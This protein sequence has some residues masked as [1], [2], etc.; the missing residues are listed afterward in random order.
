M[1]RILRGVLRFSS[2]GF[3]YLRIASRLWARALR[4]TSAQTGR[5]ASLWASFRALLRG[6]FCVLGMCL[7]KTL[8][9]R[10]RT[11]AGRRPLWYP[12]AKDNTT[13]EVASC[14]PERDWRK[15]N[16]LRGNS[17]ANRQCFQYLAHVA[18]ANMDRV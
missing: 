6:L 5:L 11:R 1:D 18:V 3:T 16:T 2:G 14:V 17:R 7:P 8:I 12:H 4:E 15:A 10:Q 13:M 9:L